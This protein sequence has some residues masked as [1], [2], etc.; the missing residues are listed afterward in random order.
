M[1]MFSFPQLVIS[2]MEENKTWRKHTWG[3][4]GYQRISLKEFSKAEV[5]LNLFHMA[6]GA[7]LLN[8]TFDG[9]FESAQN[10]ELWIPSDIHP[11]LSEN[12]FNLL[13]SQFSYLHDRLN[14]I[15]SAVMCIT[16]M[17]WAMAQSTGPKFGCL[18]NCFCIPVQTIWSTTD[19]YL[20]CQWIAERRL[21]GSGLSQA[22]MI[23]K[24]LHCSSFLG[25]ICTLDP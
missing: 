20:V 6:R 3:T 14:Q 23:F 8:G 7:F 9:R 4:F 19:G 17:I 24:W 25:K 2:K 16:H 5:G 18:C 22:S 10:S 11:K 12:V 13:V 1:Q 15:Y 21:F